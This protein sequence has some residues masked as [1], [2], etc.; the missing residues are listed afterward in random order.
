M[1]TYAH[2]ARKS[3]PKKEK[4]VTKRCMAK[5]VKV[6]HLFLEPVRCFKRDVF[7]INFLALGT[8]VESAVHNV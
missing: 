2:V 8:F 6:G 5:N 4:E 3:P 7:N 1:S